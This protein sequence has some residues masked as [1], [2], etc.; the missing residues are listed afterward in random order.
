MPLRGER[1]RPAGSFRRPGENFRPLISNPLNGGLKK[2]GRR[3]PA[4]RRTPQ[5][6]GLRYPFQLHRPGSLFG[7]GRFASKIPFGIRVHL[8]PPAVLMPVASGPWL[9]PA[10]TASFRLKSSCRFWR[11]K[12]WN[13]RKTPSVNKLVS[14]DDE[15]YIFPLGYVGYPRARHRFGRPDR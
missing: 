8:C 7:A 10:S 11:A 1:L 6:S 12:L 14:Y 4:G 13:L 3:C 15:A 5:A 9:N 2:V